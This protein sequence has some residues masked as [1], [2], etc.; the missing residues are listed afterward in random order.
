MKAKQIINIVFYNY[1]EGNE[2]KRNACIFYRDGSVKE[3]TYEDGIIACEEIVKERKITSTDVFREMINREIVHV[4]SGEDFK[5]KFQNYVNKE[6]IDRE[7][8]DEVISEE[9]PKIK[10]K[11]NTPKK[12]T[13]AD[14]LNNTKNKETENL[15]SAAT[16][17]TTVPK[18]EEDEFEDEDED[19]FIIEGSDDN[20]DYE[21]DGRIS[22]DED[23]FD[24][25]DEF[26]DDFDD[27]YEDEDEDDY[28]DDDDFDDKD[29]YEDEDDEELI[30]EGSDTTKEAKVEETQ[31]TAR[32]VDDFA[33]DYDDDYDDDYDAEIEDK[34]FAKKE[35]KLSKF[36][37]KQANK[38]R[39]I[40]AGIIS[41]AVL[42]GL[43]GTGYALKGTKTGEMI[44]NNIKSVST[45]IDDDL[46]L[47]NVTAA[48][49]YKINLQ[50]SPQLAGVPK[51][52]LKSTG[53]DLKTGNNDDYDDYTYEELLEVTDNKTQK[54]AMTNL[55]TTIME[56]NGSFAD[57][58]VEED[59]DIRAALKVEEV[60]A[61]QVAY[62]DYSKEELKAIFNGTEVRADK[63]SMDYHAA[64]MQLKGAYL[65]ETSENPVDMSYLL[66]TQ[67]GKDFYNKYH[68]MYLEAKEA[69]GQDRIDKVNAF[70]AEVK[71]DFPITQEIRTEGI[72]HADAYAMLESYKLAV[73]PMI[74][75]A[76][77]LFQN[78]ELDYTLNDME[79]DFINDIGLCNYADDEFERLETITLS[80]D[81]DKTNPTELQYRNSL[82]KVLK[83]ENHYVI[84]DAHRELTKLDRYQR[85]LEEFNLMNDFS[86]SGIGGGSTSYTETSSTSTET[87]EWTETDT[88]YTTK[89][90][91]ETKEIPAEEKAKI[92]EQINKE[93]EEARKKAEE[94]A[95][96][97]EKE[98]QAK[99]DEEARKKQEEVEN[100]N[101]QTKKD[102]EDAN[103]KINNNNKD[104]DTSND[105][106]VNEKDFKNDN[107]DFDDDHSDKDGNLNDSVKDITTDGTNDKTDEDLPDPN[108]TGEEFD[109]K[110]PAYNDNSNNNSNNVTEF[111]D[112][113][114]E[115]NDDSE[116]TDDTQFRKSDDSSDENAYTE[117]PEGTKFYDEDGN[118]YDTYEE[119]YN[120]VMVNNYIKGLENT[121]TET[122]AQQYTK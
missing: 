93:N 34:N 86:L 46:A 39:N 104:N 57:A 43:G 84:D 53:T 111:K 52:I 54:T 4:M 100:Y 96:Q 77:M 40:K 114:E 44:K 23:D 109:N 85:L 68:T 31:D 55:G 72:A 1:F 33:N 120:A 45:N 83:A 38:A 64:S 107:V 81:E 62:N 49:N 69:T 116:D 16:K 67:E 88:K 28:Y 97:K 12:N 110:A 32:E 115:S 19:D 37:H 29:D 74:A 79:V 41:L 2:E 8:I 75:S 22:T 51:N 24:D 42:I 36:F 113:S 35:S 10:V 78:L 56:F 105:T 17:E 61:L 119:W 11:E 14:R 58:Y 3:T 76:E 73:T 103:D 122:D 20:K 59:K 91:T 108:K 102:I 7:M 92:D 47:G 112:I 90:T 66:E 117:Y 82:I 71:K 65:I 87:K 98:L 6:L 80:A 50:S 27:D 48:D 95:K 15:V 101:N 9:M 106:K 99:A 121:A 25:E 94:E 18:A 118:E 26:D 60:E 63:M 89:T 13:M 21:K 30:I 70:Y 5:N